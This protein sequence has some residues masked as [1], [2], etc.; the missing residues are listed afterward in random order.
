MVDGVVMSD[1]V[2]YQLGDRGCEPLVVLLFFIGDT[3]FE[4]LVGAL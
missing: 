2:Y 1:L 3:S 4:N